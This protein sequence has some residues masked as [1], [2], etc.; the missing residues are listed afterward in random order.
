[1]FRQEPLIRTQQVPRYNGKELNEDFG[2]GWYAYGAIFY[3]PVIARFTGVDPISDKF[4]WVSTYNYAEN[5][6]IASIDL[7]G[8]Q[9]YIVTNQYLWTYQPVNQILIYRQLKMQ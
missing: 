7:H 8:L 6:P 9:R 3:D 2:W 1:M 4:P 5:E